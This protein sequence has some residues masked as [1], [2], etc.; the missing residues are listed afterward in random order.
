[1]DKGIGENL[2]RTPTETSLMRIL[3]ILDIHERK[4]ISEAYLK[5]NEFID[6]LGENLP[7]RIAGK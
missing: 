6:H 1:M 3:Y 2:S 7:I 4:E 5:R